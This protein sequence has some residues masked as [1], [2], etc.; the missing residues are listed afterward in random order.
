M[1][2]DED[3]W[4]EGENLPVAILNA[5]PRDQGNL[6]RIEYTSD[7]INQTFEPE[8]PR[9]QVF[10]DEEQVDARMI[11][12][13]RRDYLEEYRLRESPRQSPLISPIFPL[14]TM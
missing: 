2:D 13:L 7:I 8:V 9:V 10:V 1:F 12:E 3:R 14:T 4:P 11:Y 5:I 6:L